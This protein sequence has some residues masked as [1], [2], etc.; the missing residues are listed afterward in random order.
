[1]QE[2]C[3][4]YLVRSWKQLRVNHGKGR[5]INQSRIS[6]DGFY[7]QFGK[8]DL[9]VSFVMKGGLPEN[10]TRLLAVVSH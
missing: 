8:W 10:M 9:K 6:R 1:M 4:F 7:I 2:R 3:T 5:Y